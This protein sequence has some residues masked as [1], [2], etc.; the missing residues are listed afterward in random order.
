MR[1]RIQQRN[2]QAQRLY[3]R[4]TGSEAPDN[5]NEVRDGLYKLGWDYSHRAG[6]YYRRKPRPL[7]PLPTARD[8][9]RD[10]W[11]IFRT[12]YGVR[13]ADGP[14]IYPADWD[15]RFLAHVP[16]TIIDALVATYEAR[17]R[18]DWIGV[19]YRSAIRHPNSRDKTHLRH[20]LNLKRDRAYTVYVDRID[21]ATYKRTVYQAWLPRRSVQNQ[22]A[23]HRAWVFA[24]FSIAI[25]CDY[26]SGDTFLP[27]TAYHLIHTGKI[28]GRERSEVI[29][30]Q[31]EDKLMCE[32]DLHQVMQFFAAIN[33]NG[34]FPD[35]RMVAYPKP[36]QLP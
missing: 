2:E 8:L 22:L 3:A 35:M 27:R 7:P 29:Q 36:G 34:F 21:K 26:Y 33:M 18:S 24:S 28:P 19:E 32:H 11:R 25:V 16:Q 5:T 17:H 1:D 6:W 23:Q 12:S 20:K 15:N 13:H 9:Y 14:C 30:A 31:A 4:L 10:G